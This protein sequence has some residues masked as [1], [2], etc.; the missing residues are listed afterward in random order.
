MIYEIQKT[1]LP[2]GNEI[3]LILGTKDDGVVLVIP[4]D[5][6]NSDYQEYLKSLENADQL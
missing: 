6:G 2:N 1:L 5:E 4:C 3:T